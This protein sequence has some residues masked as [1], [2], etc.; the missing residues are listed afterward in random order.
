MA[1]NATIGSIDMTAMTHSPTAEPHSVDIVIGEESTLYAMVRQVPDP[2]PGGAS[3]IVMDVSTP[4]APVVKGSVQGL[5]DAA[6]GIY[7]LE[8]AAWNPGQPALSLSL[9][10]VYWASM[11]DYTNSILSVDFN[12]ANGGPDAK[13]VTITGTSNSG[14]VTSVNTPSLPQDIA[15]AGFGTFTVEYYIPSGVTAFGTTVHASAQSGATI[16]S[17]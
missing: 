10:A 15:T 4:L 17:Y 12:I 14:G 13:D 16:Y 5:N 3:V 11:A 1:T 9:G 7:V 8:K 2:S 6:C